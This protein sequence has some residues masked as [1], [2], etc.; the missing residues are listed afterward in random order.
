VPHMGTHTYETQKAM[1]VLVI[2]NIHSAITKGELL[3]P[4][5]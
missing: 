1:E 3:T 4:V 5:N 2:D